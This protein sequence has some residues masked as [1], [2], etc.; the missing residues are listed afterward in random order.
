MR[1]GWKEAIRKKS[2]VDVFA[3]WRINEQVNTLKHGDLNPELSF[4]Y[5]PEGYKEIG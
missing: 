2:K 1:Q 5:E 3:L 4:Y